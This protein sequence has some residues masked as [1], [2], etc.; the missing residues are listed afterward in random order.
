MAVFATSLDSRKDSLI[1]PRVFTPMPLTVS[2][3]SGVS[4]MTFRVSSPKVST[5][6]L[7]VAGPMPRMLPAARK[8]RIAPV[9]SGSSSS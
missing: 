5:S 2:S 4:S 1:F 9:P 6:V 7:A 8:S 3:F